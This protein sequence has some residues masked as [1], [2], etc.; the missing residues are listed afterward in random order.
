MNEDKR[1]RPRINYTN[2]ILCYKHI[3]VNR[4]EISDPAPMRITIE[5][6]SYSGLG[7]LTTRKLVT[8]DVLAFNLENAGEK[9]EVTLEVVWCRYYD[10]EYEAGLRFIN[11]T[12]EIIFFL[13]RLM[14]NYLRQKNHSY[15][16]SLI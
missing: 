16:V 14:K 10:G 13:D 7:I 4:N 8:G 6:M 12:R 15:N 11:L 5:N 9:K 1:V 2:H 3:P